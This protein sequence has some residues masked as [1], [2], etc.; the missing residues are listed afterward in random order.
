[1]SYRHPRR[2]RAGGITLLEV[3]IVVA[4]IAVLA[5]V[6]LPTYQHLVGRGWRLKAVACLEDMAQGMARRRTAR[7]TY[8]GTEPPPNDCVRDGEEAWVVMDAALARRYGFSFV[9]PPDTRSF[10]LQASPL[11]P[12]IGTDGSCGTLTLDQAGRRTVSG[13]ADPDRCW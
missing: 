1:M 2:T 5:S 12:Q 8:A 9:D 3:L 10:A 4:L 13:G 11:G 7:M 6:A